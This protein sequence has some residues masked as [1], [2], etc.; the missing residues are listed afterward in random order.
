M[1]GFTGS[2]ASG[3]SLLPGASV[4]TYVHESAARVK[5]SAAIGPS[6]SVTG[7]CDHRYQSPRLG[8]LQTQSY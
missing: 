1:T 3:V 7:H 8:L 5:N 4:G 2:Y 6:S